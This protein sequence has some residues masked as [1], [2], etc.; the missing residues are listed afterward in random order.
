MTLLSHARAANDVRIPLRKVRAGFT[1]VHFPLSHVRAGSKP[2]PPPPPPPRRLG[3]YK[4]LYTIHVVYA[5]GVNCYHLSQH[6]A[7]LSPICNKNNSLSTLFIAVARRGYFLWCRLVNVI[8]S[9][10]LP[11][12]HATHSDTLFTP[13]VHT[14][15]HG[16]HKLDQAQAH[17]TATAA[18][19]P[20][21][22]G[23]AAPPAAPAG[24]PPTRPPPR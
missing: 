12:T 6:T 4:I 7:G 22:I 5:I 18:I 16:S 9:S 15:R 20:V 21:G 11:H 13:R 3:T 2:P 10:P 8:T 1:K 24:A 23:S 17:N 19:G 14:A